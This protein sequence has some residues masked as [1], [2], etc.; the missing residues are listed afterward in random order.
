MPKSTKKKSHDN[1]RAHFGRLRPTK[2]PMSTTTM[3]LP[4][5]KSGIQGHVKLDSLQAEVVNPIAPPTSSINGC[6]EIEMEDY[7][8][9][10]GKYKDQKLKDIDP[11]Y[12]RYLTKLPDYNDIAV[13]EYVESL[14]DPPYIFRFGKYKNKRLD[15]VYKVDPKYLLYLKTQEWFKDKKIVDEFL[16]NQEP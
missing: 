5:P 13:I 12:L 9:R 10:Y 4:K 1:E 6:E 7:Q 14:G 11:N 16:V 15:Q 2:P 3:K 8:I